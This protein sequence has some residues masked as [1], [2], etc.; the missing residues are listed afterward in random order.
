MYIKDITQLI[1]ENYTSKSKLLEG[2][3][4][5][6]KIISLDG[7][8]GTLKLYDGT[9]VPAI[10]V[11]ESKPEKEKF[12]KFQIQGFEDEN[13]VLKIINTDE[14]NYKESSIDSIIKNL[15]IP[16]KEGTEII[17]SLIKFNLP[18]TEENIL[19][20]Y[21]NNS[22]INMIMKYS[23][24]DILNF[25]KDNLNINIT[26]QSKEFLIAKD[27]F[28]ILKSID[29]D[30]LTFLIENDIPSNI[31][32]ILKTNTF[33][34]DKFFINKF[35]DTINSI[36]DNKE[37]NTKIHSLNEFLK[38]SKETPEIFNLVNNENLKRILDDIDIIKHLY[39]NYNLYIFNSYKN[40]N[41]FKNH[42]IIKNKFKKSGYFDLRDIKVFISIETPKTGVVEGYL[43][44]DK[45]NIIVNLKVEDKY[46]KLFSNKLPILKD[47]LVKK[48]YNIIGLSVEKL[49]SQRNLPNLSSFFNDFILKELD[50]LV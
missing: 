48:G 27:L 37:N 17:N 2:N 22:F 16:Q 50:V 40:E 25:L 6:G 42:I 43:H 21:K 12:I 35:L 18:A 47:S 1:E 45:N 24:E 20:L 15:S 31:D 10:F 36:F 33:I 7:K 44:K 26:S 49:T 13:L 14:K 28:N 19:N 30:F 41:L 3:T 4:V 5:Y 23:D 38:L 11:S 32:E 34:K 9:L 39:N 29:I 46:H 8:R